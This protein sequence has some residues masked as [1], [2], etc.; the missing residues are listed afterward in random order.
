MTCSKWGQ[1]PRPFRQLTK[2]RW[3]DEK[4]RKL[5]VATPTDTVPTYDESYG[6]EH[7]SY[8]PTFCMHGWTRR[9]N[10]C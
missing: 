3:V 9:C 8:S 4:Q 2:T 10:V 5:R 1:C 6:R 7:T